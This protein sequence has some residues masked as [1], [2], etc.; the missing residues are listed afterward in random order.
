MS[1]ISRSEI[2]KN[3]FQDIIT[4]RPNTI[5]PEKI[6]TLVGLIV[7]AD[8]SLGELTIQYIDPSIQITLGSDEFYQLC[9][10]PEFIIYIWKRVKSAL[11]FKLDMDIKSIDF[12]V[13]YNELNAVEKCKYVGH[14]LK[15][16]DT[17][18]NNLSSGV[19]SFF[20]HTLQGLYGY[21]NDKIT[22]RQYAIDSEPGAIKSFAERTQKSISFIIYDMQDFSRTFL[23]TRRI[24]PQMCYYGRRCT[25]T[26][27]VKHQMR[28]VHPLKDTGFYFKSLA[29]KK[30]PST[31]RSY[32]YGG[33]N[34]DRS[35]IKFKKTKYR[36]TH[37]KR[38]RYHTRRRHRRH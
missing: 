1:E 30:P 36:R 3:T 28:F 14:I 24:L 34:S 10:T 9:T 33:S 31:N 11:I 6:E 38:R 16:L 2:F 5:Q 13:N 18:Y 4:T 37:T 15:K 22:S 25:S 20:S 35:K 19:V 23:S 8:A 32:P 17:I 27:D 12:P 26:A 21:L 29:P 7:D